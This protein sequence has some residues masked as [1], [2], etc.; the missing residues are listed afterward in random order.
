ME[1]GAFYITSR[2][3]LL[4]YKNRIS[5]KIKAYEMNAD[6]A[7]EIDEPSDWIIVE[8]LMRR[9]KVNKN[10]NKASVKMFLTDC[11]GCLTDGGMYYSEDGDEL[12][13]F[14]ARDG[15]GFALL[16]EH[17][18]ITGVIT[19]ENT[20]IVKRRAQKLQIDEVHQGV[21][22]KL[23]I[24][25]Q[26]AEKYHVSLDEIAYVG[27]DVNDIGALEKVGFSCTVNNALGEIKEK[28]GYVSKRNGGEGAVREIIDRILMWRREE[29][30]L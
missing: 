10:R 22:N 29:L 1:N 8:F 11:D 16:K 14:N 24:I 5:G 21:K 27:D 28:V 3:R 7:V 2:E 9:R 12:K 15:L 6:T 19:G 23:E 4:K 13:K 26:L 18:I 25:E 20:D 30:E 17:G